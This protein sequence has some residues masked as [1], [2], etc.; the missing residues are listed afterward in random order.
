MNTVIKS[1]LKNWRARF[2]ALSPLCDLRCTV[3]SRLTSTRYWERK[4]LQMKVTITDEA[5]SA[6]P[7]G[8]I[9][10][11]VLATKPN[12][13]NL[14]YDSLSINMDKAELTLNCDGI[15]IVRYSF[16][17]VY[18]NEYDTFTVEGLQGV[19]SVSLSN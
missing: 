17:D 4:G 8:K 16:S 9:H 10:S 11:P 13:I 12:E 5:F 6:L 19:I 2:G 15:P 1:E 18:I 14:K 3:I 7:T